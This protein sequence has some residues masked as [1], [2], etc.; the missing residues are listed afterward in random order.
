VLQLKEAGYLTTSDVARVL[1][2]GTTTLRRR[3]GTIYPRAARIGGI[4]VYHAA[5]V[6]RLRR[7]DGVAST[8]PGGK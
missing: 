6:E 5:D 8:S 7:R 4:R 2:I 3:E 1:G